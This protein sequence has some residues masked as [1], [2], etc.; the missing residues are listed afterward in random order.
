MFPLILIGI[1]ILVAVATG[2]TRKSNP[3]MSKQVTIPQAKVEELG[4]KAAELSKD[5]T[6]A[7]SI[8][9]MF[10]MLE[11][12]GNRTQVL[13]AALRKGGDLGILSASLQSAEVGL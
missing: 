5:G 9:G 6:Q 11:T 13:L 3:R 7:P 2:G 1:G 12:H 10:R 4:A 8:V